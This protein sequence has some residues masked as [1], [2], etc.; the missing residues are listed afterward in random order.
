MLALL[1]LAAP[2][3]G[4]AQPK[5]RAAGGTQML[6]RLQVCADGE[7]MGWGDNANYVLA[8]PAASSTFNAPVPVPDPGVRWVHNIA[9]T[10]YASSSSFAIGD[11]G[12][13]WAW[14]DN[15]WGQLGIGSSSS[16][17]TEPVKV[18]LPRPAVSVAA[19]D[20]FT[21]ALLDDGSVWAWGR[22]DN[23]QLGIG[24][25]GGAQYDP[26]PTKLTNGITAIASGDGF[27]LALDGTGTVWSW[28]IGPHGELGNG[29]GL[30]SAVPTPKPVSLSAPAW[31]LSA[32]ATEAGVVLQGGKVLTWGNNTS[33]QLGLG[34]ISSVNTTPALVTGLSG[35]DVVGLA[36]ASNTTCVLLRDGST[37]V[38]GYNGAGCFGICNGPTAS[39]TPIEGPVFGDCAQL[40]AVGPQA[41]AVTSYSGQVQTWG[42]GPAGFSPYNF[43]CSPGPPE[44]LCPARVLPLLLA[45]ARSNTVCG[46]GTALL[47]AVASQAGLSFSW[48]NQANPGVVLSTASSFTLRLDQ[49]TTFVVRTT[50]PNGCDG[51][52]ATVVVTVPDNCC[53]RDN[54]PY[55]ELDY[56]TPYAPW[57]LSFQPNTRYLVPDNKTVTLS[58]GQFILPEGAT[59]LL[60]AYSNLELINGASLIVSG[61][62]ITA[63]CDDMW[64]A[65]QVSRTAVGIRTQPS[66]GIRSV[67]QHGL[68]GIVLEDGLVNGMTANFHFDRTD[69]NHNKQSIKILRE[70]VPGTTS[71]YLADCR[72]DSD[73]QKFKS[74]LNKQGSTYYYS[75]NHIALN[76]DVR[77]RA[78][79]RNAFNHAMYGVLAVSHYGN[80]NLINSTFDNCYVAGIAS[81]DING[82]ATGNSSYSYEARL[83]NNTFTLPK[84]QPGTPQR[85]AAPGIMFVGGTAG[86]NSYGVCL[87]FTKL[88]LLNN[89]FLQPDSTAMLSYTYSNYRER[90]IGVWSDILQQASE[91]NFLYL[92]TGIQTNIGAG[93][94]AEVRGNRMRNCQ[95]GIRVSTRT[96]SGGLLIPNLTFPVLYSSCNTFRR[97]FTLPGISYGIYVE[98][99]LTGQSA[100]ALLIDEPQ[101]VIAGNQNQT[102]LK[103]L[104]SE[105]SAATGSYYA[106]YNASGSSLNYTTFKNPPGAS[107]YQTRFQSYSFGTSVL[108][109]NSVP[110][111]TPGGNTCQWEPTAF[112]NGIQSRPAT[113]ISGSG[114]TRL[115]LAASPNPCSVAT[116]IHYVAPATSQSVSLLIRRG[117]DEIPVEQFS[118]VKSNSEFNLSLQTYMPGLYFYTLFIDG[119]AVATERL[120][121][122]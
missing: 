47:Q 116:T 93:W 21:L 122:K 82:H 104:F 75:E 2:R 45:H 77:A 33:G 74:P 43:S 84:E 92:T 6:H 105:N 95:Y 32:S 101:A 3:P 72:F 13:L 40:E 31:L 56:S 73:Y 108:Q 94:A 112:T 38:W 78:W 106:I 120:L 36:M 53:E 64:E 76:G 100:P 25:I 85:S 7:L 107:G 109:G 30:S 5:A 52:T 58:G 69:F 113:R 11:D 70:N 86:T 114:L 121:V 83:F 90:Q 17:A 81:A 99:P 71:D 19:S 62:T 42:D 117:I 54:G 24:Y 115:E 88:Q 44:G 28:G 51:P 119:T 66:N 9:V 35:L 57:T 102:I 91:N 87:P 80:F 67:I 8:Q 26:M 50:L 46:G 79:A 15:Y 1:T 98:A 59:L 27:G 110:I 22:N 89:R 12:A 118:L 14:G 41:F 16:T 18:Y 63:A 111:S 103:D 49:T 20:N 23:G 34:T 37:R 55:V 61:A 65:I 60:G 97:H 48:T 96:N 39:S 29:G 4:R 10:A 68:Q